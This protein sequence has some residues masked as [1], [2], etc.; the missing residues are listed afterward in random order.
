M[1]IAGTIPYALQNYEISQCVRMCEHV[2]LSF[3]EHKQFMM[4]SAWRSSRLT[5]ASL[6]KKAYHCV[7]CGTKA[8]NSLRGAPV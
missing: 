4:S 1:Q 3:P 7:K 2:P 8:R 6:F 5:V